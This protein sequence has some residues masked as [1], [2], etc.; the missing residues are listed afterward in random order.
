MRPFGLMILSSFTQKKMILGSLA[1][2]QQTLETTSLESGGA[3]T[4]R[5]VAPE[6]GVELELF[7]IST[8][9]LTYL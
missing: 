7:Q 8:K 4:E 5:I 2:D 6:G 3:V 9:F 1:L